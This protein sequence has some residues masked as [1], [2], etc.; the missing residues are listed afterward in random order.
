MTSIT[1]RA[2]DTLSSIAKANNTT[3]S[4]LVKANN[5][6]NPD[7]I[8][9]NQRL[10]IPDRYE[11]GASSYTVKSG[12]TL[13]AIAKQYGTT[14]DALVQ[15][16]NIPDRDL[17]YP[18]QKLKIPGL[19]APA[20]VAGVESTQS[21]QGAQSAAL[22]AIAAN[23][24][25]DVFE[26][27]VV[28]PT[29]LGDELQALK[30]FPGR[31][32]E[33]GKDKVQ[34]AWVA[35]ADF[36]TEMA[37]ALK[38]GLLVGPG[39]EVAKGEV[40]SPTLLERA[41][42]MLEVGADAVKAGWNATVEFGKDTANA[43]VGF[44][45]DTA[46]Q[47]SNKAEQAYLDRIKGLNSEGDTFTIGFGASGSFLSGKAAGERD[48]EIRRNGDNTYSVTVGGKL[49]GGFNPTLVD[50]PGKSAKAELLNSLGT[51]FEYKFDTPEEAAKAATILS[52]QAMVSTVDTLAH[53]M[54]H[55]ALAKLG[56]KATE[57]AASKLLGIEKPVS[58]DDKFLSKHF[59]S[60]SLSNELAGKL[61]G[62][63]S[64]KSAFEVG[65]EFNLA[66][67]GTARIEFE[68]GKAHLVVEDELSGE[69]K[70]TLKGLNPL[71]FD[72]GIQGKLTSERRFELESF[73][74]E[75]FSK[76]PVETLK[77][78]LV[79]PRTEA[80]SSVTVSLEGNLG[81]KVGTNLFKN[82]E[83]PLAGSTAGNVT[84]RI[85][86]SLNKE[87][88]ES[89]LN[90]DF[91]KAAE[92]L[93][94][95]PVEMKVSTVSSLGLNAEQELTVAGTGASWKAV[96]QTKDRTE[97]FSAAGTLREALNHVSKAGSNNE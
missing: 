28:A 22:P 42:R 17:I 76:N 75:D 86:R 92:L 16:N 89:I 30:E 46:Q 51:K 10:V 84:L 70:G 50:V 61:K 25:R 13:S 41:G 24:N 53:M 79:R 90:L 73:N 40:Q 57:A 81:T 64:I 19:V 94:N 93:G 14:V 9:P 59:A 1:V 69:L 60:I 72:G 29:G 48:L 45:K 54:P 5:I 36:R 87:I 95:I 2:G 77:K 71:Q 47:I 8:Q 32:L 56:Q 80:G 63:L 55:M 43:A 44:V 58:E 12:D 27:G 18:N 23:R 62:E 83:G 52:K 4:A 49:G 67:T 66:K 34:A 96:A 11:P 7:F 21:T 85:D 15:E 35:T 3:V 68:K 33:A 6:G 74:P 88:G 37:N 39:A 20:P 91:A 97:V 78:V 31:V 38:E 26:G 82:L 65:G